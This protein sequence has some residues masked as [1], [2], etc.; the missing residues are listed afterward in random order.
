MFLVIFIQVLLFMISANKHFNKLT[1]SGMLLFWSFTIYKGS[2]GVSKIFKHS[3]HELSY[4]K[5]M[6]QPLLFQDDIARVCDDAE[7]A[8][9]GNNLVNH[10]MEAKLLDFNL[11]KSVYMVIGKHS[12][13][14]EMVK[15]LE[16]LPLT[17]WKM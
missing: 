3:A 14:Q 4:G 1:P 15:K 2:N 10:V 13:R 16:E 11:D 6:L 9:H 17:N 12:F 8:Q 7:A 5:E